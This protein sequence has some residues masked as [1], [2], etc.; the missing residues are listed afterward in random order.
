LFVPSP[1]TA[2]AGNLR[3]RLERRTGEPPHEFERMHMA[4]TPGQP[5]G[6]VE[7]RADT[8]ADSRLI[9]VFDIETQHLPLLETVAHQFRPTGR[10]R[11]LYPASLH[12]VA[13]NLQVASVNLSKTKA[14]AR[15]YAI[16]EYCYLKLI[17]L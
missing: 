6:I 8:F 3:A 13:I 16:Y 15:L 12:G 4:A 14:Y 5:S 10:M 1:V 11:G 9:K 7:R 17:V 2:S